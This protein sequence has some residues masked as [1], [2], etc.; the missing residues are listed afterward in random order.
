M[1]DQQQKAND[2]VRQLN[3]GQSC[4]LPEQ[5]WSPELQQAT[6]EQ[7]TPVQ[8]SLLNV[9]HLVD[10]QLIVL[11]LEATEQQAAALQATDST[12]LK[13][14][15]R[16]WLQKILPLVLL[17]A[18]LT[19]TALI[20]SGLDRLVGAGFLI[21]S[22]CIMGALIAYAQNYSKPA[23]FSSVM[24]SLLVFMLAII[25]LSVLVLH[26]GVIC[27]LIASPIM[28]A[29]LCAG[30]ALMHW[31]CR[32]LWKPQRG[33][34]SLAV[35]PLLLILIPEQ[36][37]NY[38]GHTQHTQIIHAPASVVWQQI[39]HVTDIQPD[40][41]KPSVVYGIGVPYPVSGVT[42]QTPEGLIRDSVWQ[43]GV[44]FEELIQQSVPNEYLRWTYRFEDGSFPKGALDDHV[45]VGGKYF[46]VLDTAFTLKPLDAQRT[47]LTLDVNYRVST[48]VNF[49]AGPLADWMFKDFSAV[50][51]DF[52]KKRS[53]Q[54]AS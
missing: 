9:Q 19:V 12:V 2:I 22:P 28:F 33:V 44:R 38:L 10:R 42:R 47:Q 24:I 50:I 15:L 40:E 54:A 43:K 35:L 4:A 36:P 16:N 53:E 51:L 41:F 1:Q 20:G 49:Y 13:Y 30:A 25:V 29:A 45:K 21:A 6:L 3:G 14:P 23:S 48:E 46:D 32:W 26:E 8:R 27:L 5:Q 17:I 7:L 31:C 37:G 34:Y 39:N 11:S 52:Y 18:V